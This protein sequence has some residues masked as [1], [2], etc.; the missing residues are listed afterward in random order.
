MAQI[1]FSLRRIFSFSFAV[2]ASVSAF[3]GIIHDKTIPNGRSTLPR[4]LCNANGAPAVSLTQ[5]LVAFVFKTTTTV[6]SFQRKPK[7]FPSR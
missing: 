4:C 6:S 5:Y 2:S 7:D 3:Q 1:H